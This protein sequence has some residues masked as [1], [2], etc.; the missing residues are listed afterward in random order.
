M[1]FLRS[2][3]GGADRGNVAEFVADT[4]GASRWFDAM[5]TGFH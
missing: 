3:E 4:A 2:H 1:V 5:V